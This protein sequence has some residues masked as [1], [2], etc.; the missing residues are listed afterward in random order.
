MQHLSKKKYNISRKTF[1]KYIRHTLNTTLK[2]IYNGSNLIVEKHNSNPV[3]YEIIL[4][5]DNKF[6]KNW[7]EDNEYYQ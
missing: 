6:W 4:L 3:L 5:S 2:N 1:V 7:L